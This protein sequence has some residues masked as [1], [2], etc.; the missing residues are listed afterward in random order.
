MFIESFCLLERIFDMCVCE[1]IYGF[2]LW[3]DKFFCF[4]CNL[5]VVSGDGVLV[6][7]CLCLNFLINV[8]SILILFDI[9]LL[10]GMRISFFM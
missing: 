7:I 1:L 3:G 5:M 4:M 9:F 8:V 10:V 2:N 6:K